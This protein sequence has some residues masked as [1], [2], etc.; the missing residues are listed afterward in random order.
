MLYNLTFTT[1]KQMVNN[2]ALT[3]IPCIA[4]K[5]GGMPR[6]CAEASSEKA[7]NPICQPLKTT[8][9]FALYFR[10]IRGSCRGKN[11]WQPAAAALHGA[12]V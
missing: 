1:T 3:V 5:V 12:V 8:S 9:R 2:Q 11:S 7:G 10:G 4:V 6:V